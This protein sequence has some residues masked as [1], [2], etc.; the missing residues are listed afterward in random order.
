MD[1]SRKFEGKKFM[2]DGE[3]Y[4]DETKAK[5]AAARY[6]ADN[7]QTQIISEDNQHYVF[8]R[9]EIKQSPA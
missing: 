5:E 7:F 8:T 3:A 4:A 2:W 9:R 6:K 1:L